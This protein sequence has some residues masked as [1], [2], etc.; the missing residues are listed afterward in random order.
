MSIEGE[1]PRILARHDE[2]LRLI[3]NLIGNAVKY[4]IAGRAPEITVTSEVAGNEWRLC[5]ADNGV[6]IVPG[7]GERLFQ[8][9]QR[10][11]SREA[12]EGTGIGLALCRKIAEHHKGRIWAESAGEGKGSKFHV[13]LPVLREERA[14][15]AGENI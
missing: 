13:A 15:S 3:Q 4:R 1:W 14:I 6:G 10:L 12:Y 8:V 5:V 11:H 9:F 7:Q 2:I